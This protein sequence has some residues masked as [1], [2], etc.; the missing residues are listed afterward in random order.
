ME[1]KYRNPMKGGFE[2]SLTADTTIEIDSQDSIRLNEARWPESSVRRTSTFPTYGYSKPTLTSHINYSLTR[3]WSTSS[4]VFNRATGS[5]CLRF[6]TFPNGRLN[7][8]RVFSVVNG[9]PGVFKE[10]Q[11]IL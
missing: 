9:S 10:E 3:P 8:F 11:F 6:M 2:P 7:S 1:L 4:F 5:S